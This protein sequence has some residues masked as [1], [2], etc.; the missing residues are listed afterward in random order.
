MDCTEYQ[1]L[2]V[3]DQVADVKLVQHVLREAGFKAELCRVESEEQFIDSL[4]KRIPDVIISDHGLPSFD[5]FAAL[6]IA[7]QRVPDVPFIFL[8]R[9]LDEQTLIKALREGA[10]DYILKSG[11]SKLVPAILD[12][13]NS[14]KELARVSSAKARKVLSDECCRILI[15]TAEDYGMCMLDP[16]GF[17]ISWNPAILKLT[18]FTAGDILNKHLSIFFT[19]ADILKNIP[20]KEIERAI[21]E[22]K[23]KSESKTKRKDGSSFWS[24][25]TI[26]A[27]RDEHG[28]LL[29]FSRIFH[30]ITARKHTEEMIKNQN[31]RLEQNVRERTIELEE[32]N[33]ELEAFSYSVSHD[34]RAPLRHISGFVNIL[35]EG[36]ADR[37]DESSQ[38]Y[39]KIISD[40]V[41]Q[42][43]RLIEN[44]LSFSRTGRA[45][46]HKLVIN[47]ETIF[48]MA[49]RDLNLELAKREVEWVIGPFSEVYGDPNLLRQVLVN[50][51]SNALKYTKTRPRAK[52][53]VST[54][55]TRD[56]TVFRISDNGVGFDMKYSSKL[57][58]VFQ[59]LHSEPEFEGT[60][61][62]LANVRRIIQRH[63]GKTWA[64]G[65]VNRGATFY[66]S[67]PLPPKMPN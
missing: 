23:S 19:E 7:K 14:Q 26:T 49:L 37:F 8:S 32:A 22:G 42:M 43:D 41:K 40:S 2:M 45:E 55:T 44:L 66:F 9:V 60:G 50:L 10:S 33:K 6:K 59:R 28:S 56:E 12:S 17:I 30:D 25:W 36:S 16:N 11:L 57:F 35:Q 58:G 24:E 39:L 65:T 54:Q 48:Q 3:E 64:E 47:L 21:S 63:G 38:C 15:E 31:L 61:I 20:K 13:I 27:I 4:H 18:G 52:I 67:L 46:M 5:G 62:G 29:G 1:I 51:I 53:E 34:L